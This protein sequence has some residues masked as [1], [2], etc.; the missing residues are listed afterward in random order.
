MLI[1]HTSVV[2]VADL[3]ARGLVAGDVGVVVHVYRGGEVCE[4]EFVRY[5]GSSLGTVT[6]GADQVRAAGARD[7]PHAR[8]LAA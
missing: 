8:E 7:V 1:E 6:L 3:P 4:V 5:D 2:L